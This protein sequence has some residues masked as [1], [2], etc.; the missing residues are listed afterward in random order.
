MHVCLYT[1]VQCQWRLDSAVAGVKGVS[2]LYDKGTGNL[3]LGKEKLG[4]WVSVKWVLRAH[5][6]S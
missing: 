2:K 4:L 5:F 6:Q 1:Q 3:M